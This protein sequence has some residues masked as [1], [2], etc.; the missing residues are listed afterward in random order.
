M[1]VL[2]VRFGHATNS[3]STHS[4]V[5]LDGPVAD[6]RVGGDFGWQFFTA[7]SQESRRRY[8][9]ATLLGALSGL[10]PPQIVRLI[11]ADWT[12]IPVGQFPTDEFDWYVDHQSQINI[13][14]DYGSKWPSREYAAD[15][16]AYLM[17]NGLVILGGNDNDDAD[18]PLLANG[19]PSNPAFPVDTA[20]GWICR[21]D[22]LG[23]W[24]LFHPED[25]RK[26]RFS[27]TDD[28]VTDVATT[29]E[30]VDIKITDRC[31]R[32]CRYC[33][34]NSTADG[35]HAEG[36][37]QVAYTLGQLKV[38]EAAIGGGEPTLHPGLWNFIERLA[39]HG[40]LPNLSTRSLDWIDSTEKRSAVEQ[41]C[42]G[43]AFSCD[44]SE[45]VRPVIRAVLPHPTLARKTGI[46]IVMGTLGA[47]EFREMLSLCAA[48][49]FSVTLL[50]FKGRGRGEKYK[51]ADYAWWLDSVLELRKGRSCPRLGIDT[52]LAAE[53][54][55]ELS[56][57]GVPRF[58][59]S[60]QEGTHSLYIDAVEGRIG[61]SSY[62]PDDQMQTSNL[63]AEAIADAQGGTAI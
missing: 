9:A 49:G 1:K 36:L 32:G 53:F 35:E 63:T 8:M 2:N 38:F 14:R 11:V 37:A 42:G 4:L 58:L 26:L 55:A 51:P 43:V 27:F 16:Q 3:S 17:Q 52:L 33:Y 18:H 41:H 39:Y 56:K 62:C 5:F 20:R 22:P 59:Y 21:K 48:V 61:P 19:K 31:D 40:V 12:G 54:E 7:A 28:A 10:A 34:Q 25:G 45:E 6:D 13:P 57:A 15:L 30:L 46:H 24:T 60:V 29:P 50:G 47:Y 44:Y 23:Y